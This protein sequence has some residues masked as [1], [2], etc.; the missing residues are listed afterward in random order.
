MAPADLKAERRGDTVGLQFTVPSTNTDNTRPANV[1]RVD[2]YAFTGPAAID[3]VSPGSPVSDEELLRQGTRVASVAVKA[4]RDPSQTIDPD[5]PA[6]ELEP[7]EGNGLDQGAVARVEDKVTPATAQS[8]TYVGVGITTRGRRGPISNRVAVPLGPAPPAPSGLQ[9]TYDESAVT[10]TWAPPPQASNS[11][12]PDLAYHVYEVAVPGETQLTKTPVTETTYKDT[13]M[14]W[15]AMRCYG[16]RAVEVVE[17][18]TVQ[19]EQT[20]PIC[21]T[22]TD[23]FPPAAPTGLNAVSSEGAISLIWDAN[24]EPDVDGYLVLRGVAP[25]GALAPIT[26]SPIRETTFRDTVQPGARYVYAIQAVD[27]SG[28]ASAVSNHVE[29]TAR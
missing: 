13:R 25:G 14:T 10:A 26:P 24:A 12:A 19:S 8:R 21:V 18:L 16:V 23:R 6:D 4:P 27:R 1:A 29:E 20:M 28:N 17:S 11:A 9:V 7:L 3:P 22:L 15:G 2:V 5:E